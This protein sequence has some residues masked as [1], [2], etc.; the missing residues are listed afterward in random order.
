MGEDDDRPPD[1]RPRHDRVVPTLAP[2]GLYG[3]PVETLEDEIPAAPE[4][5]PPK[6]R[7]PFRRMIDQLLGRREPPARV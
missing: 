4:G 3:L 7:G 2:E 1:D 5:E 6:P